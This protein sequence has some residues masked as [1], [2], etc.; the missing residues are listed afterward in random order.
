MPASTRAGGSGTATT[1]TLYEEAKVGSTHWLEG[2]CTRVSKYVYVEAF[3]SIGSVL[4]L[5][6]Y[7]LA[8]PDG[9]TQYVD[10]GVSVAPLNG[11][12]YFAFTPT[13]TGLDVKRGDP[14]VVPL[15]L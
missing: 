8:G 3:C 4:P 13:V 12:V 5:L 10:P 9:T 15:V 6:K 14:G 11:N 7:Q 2:F 1:E